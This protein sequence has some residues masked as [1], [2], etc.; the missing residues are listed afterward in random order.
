MNPF[1]R[2]TYLLVQAYGRADHEITVKLL[3]EEFNDYESITFS[4]EDEVA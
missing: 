2:L 3:Q 1:V 4:N